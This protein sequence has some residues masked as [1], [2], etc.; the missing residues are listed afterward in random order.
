MFN[1][2]GE[3]LLRLV[4]PLVRRRTIAGSGIDSTLLFVLSI[5]LIV[6]SHLESYYPAPWLAA[7]GL[8]GNTTFFLLSGFAISKTLRR[9]RPS[10]QS[11][12]GRRLTKLYPA[13][14]VAV[15]LG[16]SIGTLQPAVSVVGAVGMF[17]WPT[18]FTYISLIV[19][20]YVLLWFI[21]RSKVE[22]ASFVASLG[23]LTVA[24]VQNILSGRLDGPYESQ[25]LSQFTYA[26]FFLASTLAGSL[27]A[28]LD[29]KARIAPLRFAFAVAVVF[30]YFGL[31]FAMI[32]GGA[33]GF[34]APVLLLL[35]LVGV[36]AVV[37]T[38]G[39]PVLVARAVALCLASALSPC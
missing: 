5:S 19:P 34:L 24:L 36:L 18:P 6:N 31:K 9:N 32:V 22:P 38:L 23:L 1:A 37:L 3:R 16:L 2:I 13:S 20:F 35:D 21:D 10:L 17:V 26:A 27:V 39:D 11:Y 33:S 4:R 8:F 25:A 14:F 29:L 30:V 28:A 15:V 12:V 7:D